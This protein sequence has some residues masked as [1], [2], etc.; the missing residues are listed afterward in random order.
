MF[1]QKCAPYC[2]KTVTVL[3]GF[4]PQKSLSTVLYLDPLCQDG[5]GETFYRLKMRFICELQYKMNT[6]T[7]CEK[8]CCQLQYFVPTGSQ[9]KTEATQRT[10]ATLL[11]NG[12]NSPL[13]WGQVASY[14]LPS[15]LIHIWSFGCVLFASLYKYKHLYTSHTTWLMLCSL[16]VQSFCLPNT[17]NLHK[18]I[19]Y[20]KSSLPISKSRSLSKTIMSY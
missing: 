1:L 2:V 12:W 10:C 8:T 9:K 19:H 17:P 18:I 3:T 6:H 14:T 4:L 16:Q 7:S 20:Q 13:Q 5:Q 11:S 15:A